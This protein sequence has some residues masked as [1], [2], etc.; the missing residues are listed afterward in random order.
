M[1][2]FDLPP[3]YLI[4]HLSLTLVALDLRGQIQGTMRGNA[5]ASK[6]PGAQLSEWSYSIRR[7]KNR[8]FKVSSTVVAL[9]LQGEIQAQMTG[10]VLESKLHTAQLA[11]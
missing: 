10:N 11:E 4:I 1:V 6:L 9:D 7:K 3:K 8:T 2:S 5:V